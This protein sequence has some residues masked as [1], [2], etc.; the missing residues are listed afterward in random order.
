MAYKKLKLLTMN[1][2]TME[3][4]MGEYQSAS[5]S[6]AITS[7]NLDAHAEGASLTLEK[8]S[9][10]V[11]GQWIFGSASTLGVR[12]IENHV[13]KKGA[14]YRYGSQRVTIGQGGSA[15]NI[16]IMGICNLSETTEVVILGS[17]DKTSG[18][19]NTTIN[20]IRVGDYLGG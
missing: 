1:G 7:T 15:T 10:V 5:K 9:W 11:F 17:S 18:V 13:S 8:G 16:Q 3:I 19:G 14:N 20:A 4:P 12:N 6:V 2:E